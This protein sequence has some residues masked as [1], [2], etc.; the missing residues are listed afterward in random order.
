[1]ALFN[2]RVRALGAEEGLAVLDLQRD[3][4]PTSALFDDD[5]HVTAEGAQL[6]AELAAK[7]LLENGLVR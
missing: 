4:P 7:F 5:V 6:E 1:M 2:D 3:V